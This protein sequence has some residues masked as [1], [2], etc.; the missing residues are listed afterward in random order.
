[1]AFLVLSGL[2]YPSIRS[3][4]SS[5][6]HCQLCNGGPD[7]SLN[8][9]FQLHYVLRGIR[10]SLP[11][12][13]RPKCLP[14]TSAILRLLYHHWSQGPVSFDMV[15]ISAAC[16]LGFFGFLRCGQFTCQSLTTYDSL[17]LSPG[18]IK[19]DSITDPTVLHVALRRSKTDTFG[20]GVTIHLGRSG[21]ILCPVK[22]TCLPIWLFVQQRLVPSSYFHL[23]HHCQENF[24]WL[25]FAESSHH[26]VWTFQDL[27]GTVSDR[28]GNDRI[29][30]W[31][32]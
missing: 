23:V 19:V 15:C 26:F 30:G 21:D 6:R 10:R 11:S 9:F 5:L 22:A 8:T 17:M 16:C 12:H 4:L 18:D 7:P 14:I 1:M 3:Y 13:V 32:T 2:S 28:C 31:S 29:S 25:P 20:A 27:M 24:W